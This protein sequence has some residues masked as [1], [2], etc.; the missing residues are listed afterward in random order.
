[1]SLSNRGIRCLV[2]RA[3]RVF[4]FMRLFGFLHL[5]VDGVEGGVMI[6]ESFGGG[7]SWGKGFLRMGGRAARYLL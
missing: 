1:M 7:F 6:E 2:W 5:I 3:V 4:D